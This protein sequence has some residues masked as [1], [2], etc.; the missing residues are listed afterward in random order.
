MTIATQNIEAVS[1]YAFVL[2]TFASAGGTA[3]SI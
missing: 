2:L 1:P 3:D